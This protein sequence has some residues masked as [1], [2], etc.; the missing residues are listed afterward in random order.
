MYR[1]IFN[2]NRC[3]SVKGF[4]NGSDKL[5]LQCILKIHKK[6]FYY[7]LFYVANRQLL[8]LFWLYFTDGYF[9]EITA[10]TAQQIGVSAVYEKFD[11]DFQPYFVC[12]YYF[13]VDICPIFAL[14][15]CVFSVNYFLANTLHYVHYSN[16]F[17]KTSRQEVGH[18]GLN[19]CTSQ[20]DTSR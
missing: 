14:V 7:R 16:Y 19:T 8:S 18:G 2:F 13:T 4:L 15:F 3:G 12:L 1:I 20:L 17:A 11:G 10:F 6:K 5:S 9:K